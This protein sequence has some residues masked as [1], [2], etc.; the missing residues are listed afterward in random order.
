MAAK[1]GTGTLLGPFTEPGEAWEATSVT[2]PEELAAARARR[3]RTAEA[4]KNRGPGD[5]QSSFRHAFTVGSDG[6]LELLVVQAKIGQAA[7]L[8]RTCPLCQAESPSGTP[9]VVRS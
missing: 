1:K 8:P 4:R 6:G 9:R 5:A 3:G 7:A 2:V